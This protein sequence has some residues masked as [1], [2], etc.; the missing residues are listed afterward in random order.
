MSTSF[1]DIR[2]S[3]AIVY[4]LRKTEESDT[5]HP[6]QSG[7]PRQEQKPGLRLSAPWTNTKI[8]IKWAKQF[9]ARS[10]KRGCF[11]TGRDF[12][13]ARGNTEAWWQ[14]EP[15]EKRLSERRGRG[16][17]DKT[18]VRLWAGRVDTIRVSGKHG[19]SGTHRRRCC[20]RA[21]RDWGRRQKVRDKKK[22]RIRTKIPLD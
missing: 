10:R 18:R 7:H 22:W 14:C 1:L 16:G 3:V 5:S 4:C 13:R 17:R 8:S 20:V 9:R 11:Q 6:K 2:C 21:T 15:S 12:G 19:G